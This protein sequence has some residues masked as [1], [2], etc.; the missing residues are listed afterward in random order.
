MFAKL[1]QKIQEEGFDVTADLIKG[2]GVG[3]IASP[4]NSSSTTPI[5]TGKQ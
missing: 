2:F 1:K 5:Q 4:I 3:T